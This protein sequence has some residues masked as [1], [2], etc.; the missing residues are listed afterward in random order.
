MTK[1]ISNSLLGK[2]VVLSL[3]ISILAGTSVFLL[4]LKEI[5]TIEEAE[6]MAASDRELAALA[7][8]VAVLQRLDAQPDLIQSAFENLVVDNALV[9]LRI[10]QDRQILATLDRPWQNTNRPILDQLTARQLERSVAVSVPANPQ[11]LTVEAIYDSHQVYHLFAVT[12]WVNARAGVIRVCIVVLIVSLI[13][14]FLFDRPIKH[15]LSA[16]RQGARSPIRIE[17]NPNNEDEIS[18]LIDAL[19]DAFENEHIS[20]AENQNLL[21]A[22][23]SA[24]DPCWVFKTHSGEPIFVN[25]AACTKLGYPRE[26]LMQLKVWS[27]SNDGDLASYQALLKTA[28]ATDEIIRT[29]REVTTAS[30]ETIH[31]EVTIRYLVVNDEGVA[32][33]FAR[34]VGEREA[35]LT[36]MSTSERFKTIAEMSGALAHDLNNK[37]QVAM[38]NLEIAGESE[39]GSNERLGLIR[40][41]KSV[42]DTAA[43]SV[44]QLLS[45]A[46]RKFLQTESINL[47]E[48]LTELVP[49]LEQSISQKIH[50]EAQLDPLATPFSI[51]PQ[52]LS[53]SLIHI[54]NNAVEAMPEGGDLTLKL[55][56]EPV[57][58]PVRAIDSLVQPGQYAVIRVMDSGEGISEE[59]RPR[60]FEP[61]FTTRGRDRSRGLGLSMV[62]GFVLQSGG[63]IDVRSAPG[64]GTSVQIWLPISLAAKEQAA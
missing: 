58:S 40:K 9:S 13:F 63:H 15:I 64:V 20:A 11:V 33:L 52:M 60:I 59:H 43:A 62:H 12:Q 47:T 8:H 6:F 22:L 57:I 45:F 44:D 37:L 18:K 1:L 38:G 32:V 55:N 21:L 19:N 50:F 54:V 34:D 3:V 30:G 36:R 35:L 28:R 17:R 24:P 61:F 4:G 25:D 39:T 14:Y 2:A 5:F 16:L 42:L 10:S 49:M 29:F 56:E 46:R 27:L 31:F 7:Q 53:S 26:T 41:A 23:R 51:D 48:T